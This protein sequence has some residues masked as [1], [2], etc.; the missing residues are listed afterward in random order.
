MNEMGIACSICSRSTRRVKLPRASWSTVGIR[1]PKHGNRE[2]LAGGV[3]GGLIRSENVGI[4]GSGMRENLA[5]GH[6]RFKKSFGP[7]VSSMLTMS[8]GSPCVSAR[9]EAICA[10]LSAGH[11]GPPLHSG[12]AQNPAAAF[13]GGP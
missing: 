12:C 11:A 4:E 2:R 3:R 9:Y 13:F 6:V 8:I 10:S 5:R 1:I 7:F